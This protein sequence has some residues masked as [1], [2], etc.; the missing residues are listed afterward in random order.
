[1]LLGSLLLGV[2]AVDTMAE[3][4][5]EKSAEGAV[6]GKIVLVKNDVFDITD[7]RENK[8]FYRFINKLH[9]ITKDKVI[10]RQLLLKPGDK[11]SARLA[12]ESA[13]ILR[14]RRYLFDAKVEAINNHDGA[15]D[16][17]VTTKDVW[18]LKPGFSASRAGG[19]NR[20]GID[21][22]EVNLFGRG[23]KIR[24]AKDEDVDRTSRTF[25]F[26]DPHIGD[27]LVT[28]AL[29]ISD[30]SDGHTNFASLIRPFYA[31]DTRWSAG[32]A[33]FDDDHRTAF[34]S[35]GEQ[36]AEYQ[37]E[38]QLHS[39]FGGWSAGLENGW[40]RRYRAGVVFDDNQFTMV[41]TGNLPALLPEDRR[42]IY[43]FVELE[44]LEDQ[45]ET[46]SN[47]EQIGRT[48][49]FYMGE[50]LTASLG[51]ASEDFDADR[52]AVLYSS[53]YSRGFGSLETKALLTSIWASG[54]LEDGK[55][56][57]AIVRLNTRYYFHQSNKRMFT[58]TMDVTYGHALDLDNMVQLGGETGL[59][60]Y[61]LAYQS[62]DSKALFSV[63]QRYFWKWYPFRLFRVGGAIFADVGRVWGE[64]PVGEANQGWL[65]DVGFGFRFSSPRVGF[66]RMIHLDIA[67]PLDGDASLDEVQ[68]ILE[69]KSSF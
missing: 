45:F 16:L 10:E 21:L 2:S 8:S 5:T 60:G 48:E 33:A 69:S 35:L 18:T 61:P 56:R 63:E 26:R 6:I 9:I 28:A 37:H 42:L 17:R 44:L 39:L 38:R 40:V 50:R 13:R 14:S 65:R 41:E 54:R 67:F 62:G 27:N 66:R 23:Q 7:E 4:D 25:D 68:I 59:R 30:N 55:S 12:E 64:N 11:Y 34:Y 51:Y 32:A 31:L 19:E 46:T 53:S 49:D 36:E 58:A 47:K 3:E 43:P 20:I 57:N 29:T 52:S 24:I 22:E 15:V 1:V